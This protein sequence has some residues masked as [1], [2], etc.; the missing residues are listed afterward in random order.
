MEKNVNY[1]AIQGAVIRQE[2]EEG[3][4]LTFVASD[5]TRDAAGTVITFLNPDSLLF[6]QAIPPVARC[7]Q[8]LHT[9][10]CSQII[11]CCSS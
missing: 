6:A 8:R 5:E 3:R 11:Y 1:R 7:Y 2:G 9:I 10:Q 4:K